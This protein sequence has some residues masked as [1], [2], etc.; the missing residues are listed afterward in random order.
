MDPT[1][2]AMFLTFSE[3]VGFGLPGYALADENC[4]IFYQ[5]YNLGAGP[6]VGDDPGELGSSVCAYTLTPWEPGP[7]MPPGASYSGYTTRWTFNLA[8]IYAADPAPLVPA[9]TAI[10]LIFD[11]VSDLTYRMKRV[12]DEPLTTLVV[13]VPTL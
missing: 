1:N 7:L 9:G 3:P 10:H 8:A 12:T 13:H 2:P 4:V 11:A 5:I 6:L